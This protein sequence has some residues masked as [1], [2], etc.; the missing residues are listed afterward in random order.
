M[1]LGGFAFLLLFL[2][3]SPRAQIEKLFERHALLDRVLRP[4]F[5]FFRQRHKVILPF[6]MSLISQGLVMGMGAFLI[7]YLGASMPLWM[8]LLVFPFGFLATILPI[9]P[10][11]VGVGQAAFLYLFDKVAGNGEFGVLTI[12]YFQAVQ[13][14]V[15]LLG[16]LLFVLYKKREV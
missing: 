5:F 8:L 1:I 2:L 13:F 14:L 10:A 16:G 12:T 7:F 9:S 4:L 6:L 15:G 11:G 3:L